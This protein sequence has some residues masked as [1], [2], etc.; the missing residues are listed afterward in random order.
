MASSD[1]GGCWTRWWDVETSLLF[2]HRTL[3]LALSPHTWSLWSGVPRFLQASKHSSTLLLGMFS[4][5]ILFHTLFMILYFL[6]EEISLH[7]AIKSSCWMTYSALSP[8]SSCC[9]CFG[10][11]T[12]FHTSTPTHSYAHPAF[13]TWVHLWGCNTFFFFY[14]SQVA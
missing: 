6:C 10:H 11:C 4:V 14:R 2:I 5:F 3:A 1:L 13:I 8:W 12:V 9:V 7:T